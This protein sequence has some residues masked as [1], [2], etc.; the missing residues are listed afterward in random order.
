LL[1]VITLS[2]SPVYYPEVPMLSQV[3]TKS[4]SEPLTTTATTAT[5]TATTNC[6]SMNVSGDNAVER[7]ENSDINKLLE[8]HKIGQQEEQKVSE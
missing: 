2:F 7:P 8:E 3:E 5:A 4:G 6:D 1:I